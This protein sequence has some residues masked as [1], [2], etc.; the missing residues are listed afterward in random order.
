LRGKG[1]FVDAV[2]GADGG[3][4]F[5]EWAII[6]L[7]NYAANA[8][9]NPA[10]Y[11]KITERMPWMAGIHMPTYRLLDDCTIEIERYPNRN[12]NSLASIVKDGLPLPYLSNLQDANGYGA[13]VYVP[14]WYWTVNAEKQITKQFQSLAR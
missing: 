13:G 9:Y 8:T 3:K 7:K 4:L 2:F 14:R 10:G 12:P 1:S 5:G 6:G 11:D